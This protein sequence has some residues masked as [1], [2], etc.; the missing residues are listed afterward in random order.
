MLILTLAYYVETVL[1]LLLEGG[2]DFIF[3]IVIESIFDGYADF[4]PFHPITR[5]VC[6]QFYV[7]V[8]L[9]CFVRTICRPK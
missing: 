4:F 9:F 8:R 5:H 3:V 7:F 2:G 1:L 6:A